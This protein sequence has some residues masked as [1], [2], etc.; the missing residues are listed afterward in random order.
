VKERRHATTAALVLAA[1]LGLARPSAAFAASPGQPAADR[2]AALYRSG[3]LAGAREA[4]REAVR[5]DPHLSNAWHNL[6]WVESRLGNEEEAIRIWQDLL[7][8]EPDRADT[9][10]ALAALLQ[11]RERGSTPSPPEDEAPRASEKPREP[12]RDLSRLHAERATAAFQSG[13]LEDAAQSY[14]RAVEL[15]GENRL[16]LRGLGWAY[17]KAGRLDEAEG[18]WKRYARTFPTLAEPHDLLAGLYLERRAYEA[19]LAEARASLAID[20]APRGA[21]MRYIRSLS[22]V[23]HIGEARQAAASLAT[24]LPDDPQA[25]RLLADALTRSRSFGDAARQWRRVL[26]LDPASGA[27]KQ[28]WVR[29]LYESGEADAAVEAARTIAASADAPA[30]VLELLAEDGK[31][32]HDLDESARWY[33]ELTRRFPGEVLYWRNLTQTLDALGRFPEQVKVAREATE[34]LPD[35]SDLQIDLATALGNAGHVGEAIVRARRHLEDYPD[36]RAAYETLVDLL[37]NSGDVSGALEALSR[38]R[39]SFYKGYQQTMIEASLR[40][41][42]RDHAAATRLL[43]GLVDGAGAQRFVPILLYHGIVE[44][45]PTLQ[46][47]AAAFEEQMAALEAHGYHSITLRDLARMVTGEEP[48]PERP[49]LITFDDAR[50]D[51]FLLG[52]PI[53]ERHGFK[54]TMFVPTAM[55]GVEDTFHAGWATIARYARTGRWDVQAHGHEAHNL[56]TIDAEGGQGAFLVHRAFLPDRGRPESTPEYVARLDRDYASCKEDLERHL[57]EA[58]VIGYAYPFNQVAYA[59]REDG[60]ALSDVN[61]WL[62]SRYYRF[63]LVE[64]GTGYNELRVGEPAPF[65]LRRFEVPGAWSGRQLLAHLARNEPIRAARLALASL[66]VDEGRPRAARRLVDEIVREEPLVAPEGEAVLA[67]VAWEEQRPREAA[68]HLAASPPASPSGESATLANKLAWRNSSVA[69]AEST[70]FSESDGRTVAYAGAAF[71][72]PLAGQLDL[73]VGAGQLRIAERGFP[74][75]TGPQLKAELS[76]ALGHALGVTAWGRVR[77]LDGGVH[78]PPNGGLTLQLRSEQHTVS[79]QA[80]AEDVDTVQAVAKG[81]EQDSYSAAYSFESPHRRIEASGG[82]LQYTD[83]NVRNDLHGTYFHLFGSAAEWGVGASVDY[84]DSRFAPPEYYA[85]IGL[86]V[87]MG[88]LR[89][90]RTWPDSTS[91]AVSLGAGV[92]HDVPHGERASGLSGV[93]LSRWWGARNAIGTTLGVEGKVVPG[94][95]SLSGLFRL[96]FRF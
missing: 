55:V 51:S 19:A 79:L 13:R 72:R 62:P 39:P 7:R 96:E 36:S 93:T 42:Q 40:A 52:D 63:G 78:T 91:L 92:A 68:E 46:T 48:F 85:P 8:L 33:R 2:G 31:A 18:A 90:S 89:Y 23:G 69:G 16:A 24:R 95:Q 74:A 35:R 4:F 28:N 56:V 49:I 22:G 34:R 43:R 10:E 76:G 54:A 11:K 27:A 59:Q 81:I 83:G 30:K 12:T 58:R 14:T 73:Q 5:L 67:R 15:D 1:A 94:Y 29:T 41:R 86:V 77:Q 50:T 20:P 84:E 26:E 21:N 6:G 3:D 60:A 25:Q 61:E 80:L 64:D 17:R 66:A 53:L 32:R 57:P 44:H 75:F 82:R 87:G 71:R 70:V 37:A 45:T 88:R 38:N 65:M 47:S 9:R